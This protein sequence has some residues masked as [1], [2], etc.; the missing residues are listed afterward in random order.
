[1]VISECWKHDI[2]GRF[3]G[4]LFGRNLKAQ[5]RAEGSIINGL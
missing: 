4:R 3:N 1:M 2:I 5:L